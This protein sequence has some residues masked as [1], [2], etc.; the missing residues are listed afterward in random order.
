MEIIEIKVCPDHIH[1]LVS[2]PPKYSMSQIMG[3]RKGGEEQ[4]DD[5]RPT[6]E[7]KVQVRKP[8]FLGERALCRYGRKK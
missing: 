5:F 2:I 4:F 1:M 3:Y 6:C 7:F 8:L